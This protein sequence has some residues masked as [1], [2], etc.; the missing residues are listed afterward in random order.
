M[1]ETQEA[2]MA[3]IGFSHIALPVTDLGASVA[4][5][6]RY[7]HMRVVHRR[8]QAMHEGKDIAWLSDGTRAFALVLAEVDS[9]EAP[10]GPFA[11]LGVACATRGELERLCAVAQSEGV[12]RESPRDTG[13]PAGTLAMLD[14]PDGHTL[15]LSFGQ[16]VAH[17]V[18]ANT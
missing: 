15:E 14:D 2:D 17:A 12:L 6:G 1:H 9:V 7:A 10:L 4:F 18:Q 13:G 5:Y 11:H 8:T 16:E 3:D